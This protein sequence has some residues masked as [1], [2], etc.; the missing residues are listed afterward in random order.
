MKRIP[1]DPIVMSGKTGF[2]RMPLTAGTVLRMIVAG[3]SAERIIE[4]YPYLKPEH[5]EHTEAHAAWSSKNGGSDAVFMKTLVD[6]NPLAGVARFPRVRRAGTAHVP[7][8]H[9]AGNTTVICAHLL[10]QGLSGARRPTNGP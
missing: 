8:D 7:L 6:T 4:T 3:Y 1:M 10:D 9:S 2:Q 5:L